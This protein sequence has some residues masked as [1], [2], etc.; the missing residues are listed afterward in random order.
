MTDY[1]LTTVRRDCQNFHCEQNGENN[2]WW[3][4]TVKLIDL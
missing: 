4:F 1:M 2:V 3:K